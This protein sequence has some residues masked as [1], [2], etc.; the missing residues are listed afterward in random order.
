VPQLF[1]RT[2]HRRFLGQQP[3]S[4]V[5]G[6][7]STEFLLYSLSP[8]MLTQPRARWRI[9]CQ[10]RTTSHGPFRW[11]LPHSLSP[12]FSWRFV[13]RQRTS[14][15]LGVGSLTRMNPKSGEGRR[16]RH[17][18]SD[19]ARDQARPLKLRPFHRSGFLEHARS[20]SLRT[21]HDTHIPRPQLIGVTVRLVGSARLANSRQRR[22]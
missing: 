4:V 18:P 14:V 2:G 19:G 8:T 10:L 22:Y 21:G 13:E 15:A 5:D 3:T 16:E 11:L 20:G 7:W 12:A 6:G 9:R 1:A 17:P